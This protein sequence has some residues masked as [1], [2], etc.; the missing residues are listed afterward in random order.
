MEDKDVDVFEIEDEEEV[1]VD[2]VDKEWI[3][4]YHNKCL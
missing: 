2:F 4:N 3:I 1:V